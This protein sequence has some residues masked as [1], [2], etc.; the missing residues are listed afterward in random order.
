MS[1]EPR[2]ISVTTFGMGECA[3]RPAFAVEPRPGARILVQRGL[4][5]LDGY[6]AL[7]L[8]VPSLVHDAH[9]TAAKH[10][11]QPIS[12]FQERSSPAFVAGFSH[13]LV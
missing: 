9:A 11:A 5:P 13:G 2:S 3:K 6:I 4:E 7:Q 8:G 10:P 12:V 1:L